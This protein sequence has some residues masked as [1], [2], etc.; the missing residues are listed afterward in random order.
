[1]HNWY[2]SKIDI[3]IVWQRNGKKEHLNSVICTLPHT[4][5]VLILIVWWWYIPT[6]QAHNWIE[7]KKAIHF[8]WDLWLHERRYESIVNE[9]QHTERGSSSSSPCKVYQLWNKCVMRHSLYVVQN[10]EGGK[11]MLQSFLPLSLSLSAHFRFCS[12]G[13]YFPSIPIFIVK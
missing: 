10:E 7:S 8:Q 5:S 2:Q 13:V 3:P 4:N 6:W 12:E 11:L 9:R 1:M